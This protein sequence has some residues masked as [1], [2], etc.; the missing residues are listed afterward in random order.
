MHNI[1]LLIA[2]FYLMT[3]LSLGW[4]EFYLFHFDV[5]EIP[6]FCLFLSLLFQINQKF[7]F[8]VV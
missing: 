4:F 5:I 7:K 8:N 6:I 2:I 3:L 1:W